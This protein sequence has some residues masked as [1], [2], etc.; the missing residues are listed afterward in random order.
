VSIEAD[1]AL[2]E[3]EHPGELGALYSPEAGAVAAPAPVGLGQTQMVLWV[4]V[5]GEVQAVGRTVD[6]VTARARRIL[7]ELL[8][9]GDGS[10][11]LADVEAG[12]RLAWVTGDGVVLRAIV[13]EL[14]LPVPSWLQ[15][16][17]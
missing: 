16:A 3:Q 6:E 11:G 8:E 7:A 12:A 15:E 13:R 4:D 2:H 1:M 10:W 9:H 14:G 5:D 17:P